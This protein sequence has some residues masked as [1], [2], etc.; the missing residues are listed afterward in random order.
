MTKIIGLTGGIGSGK[1]AIGNYFRTLGIPVYVADEEGRK[2]TDRPEVVRQIADAFGQ[3]VIADGK[4]DRKQLAEIVFNDKEKL[5]QLNSIIH[6][7][8]KRHFFEWIEHYPDAQMVIRE[9][10][11]LFESG[12]YR[13]CDFV[14]SVTA[15]IEMRIER[16]MK[17]DNLTRE[18]V[19]ERIENQMS[20]DERIPKSDFVI[21]NIHLQD[22]EKQ[23][24]EILKNL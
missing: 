3:S 6:P 23:A 13:D 17:R 24:K 5:E 12:S 14:I 7:A 22:A 16:V 21:E 11:I 18:Q 9:S 8:V 4:V 1:T 20:D 10:A 19:M 15:P 2:I